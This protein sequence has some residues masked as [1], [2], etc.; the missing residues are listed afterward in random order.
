MAVTAVPLRRILQ[1]PAVARTACSAAVVVAA[2][3]G[4]AARRFASSA[5]PTAV[6][7]ASG[8]ASCSPNYKKI[9][10]KKKGN[11]HKQPVWKTAYKKGGG[12]RPGLK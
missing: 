12:Y 11:L 6:T 3:R 1:V 9:P 8:S 4:T 10:Q 7:T 2:A 5:R